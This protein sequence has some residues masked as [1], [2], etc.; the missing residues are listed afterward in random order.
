MRIMKSRK[1]AELPNN[2]YFLRKDSITIGARI[3]I[4]NCLQFSPSK[5]KNKGN[6][7]QIRIEKRNIN[8]K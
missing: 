1:R 6:F 5:Y 3:V 8:K 2:L 4:K 7:Q